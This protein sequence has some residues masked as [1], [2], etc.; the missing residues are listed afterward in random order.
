MF[1]EV[2]LVV[3]AFKVAKFPVVP[4]KVVKKEDTALKIPKEALV[5]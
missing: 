3:D 5:E 2:A 4:N 1:E